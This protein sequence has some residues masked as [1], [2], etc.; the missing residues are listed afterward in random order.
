MK[1]FALSLLVAVLL[2]PSYAGAFET[3]GSLVRLKREQGPLS[4]FTTQ[5]FLMSTGAKPLA[6]D[7][8]LYVVPADAESIQGNPA[9]ESVV[10]N[11]VRH[12]F[13]YTEAAK[14]APAPMKAWGIEKVGA[15]QLWKK[16]I[17]GSKDVI[18]AVIDTG[19]EY[20]HP[21]I[22]DNIWSAADG[23]HGYNAITKSLDPLDDHSHGTHCSGT[24]GGK[25]VGVNK[26]VSI[27][28]VKFL[29][30]DGSG[31]DAGA[32][33]S[34][35][36]AADH[37]AQVMS[38]SWGGGGADPELEAAIKKAGDKGILFVAAAG[39]DS[40]DND[41]QPS[42]PA[43][44]KLDNIIAVAATEKDDKMAYFSNYGIQSVHV[45]APGSGI[46]SSVLH[47]QYAEY[48]GTSMATPHVSGVVAMMLS[49]G[50]KPDEIKQTL[51]KTS[52]PVDA[53]KGKVVASGRID[54]VQA[55]TGKAM[56][57]VKPPKD[58]KPPKQDEQPDVCEIF[59]QLGLPCPQQ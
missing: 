12:L 8:E 30:A 46:Y 22:K 16:G 43:S 28:G 13:S 41:A 56:K 6:T 55:I 17:K 57:P 15:P 4:L 37:G 26:M 59:K 47:G 10:P 24:I 14:P 33:D 31:D 35:N 48:S 29:S 53:L 25:E 18:V 20:T 34:I 21:E 38:A 27:M 40:S 9:I 51:I 50:K 44:Y 32:I 2:L 19:V 42:Y 39:N 7:S 45:A 36:W 1:N 11:Y 3:H 23:T 5:N 58:S 52:T 49:Q 54:A